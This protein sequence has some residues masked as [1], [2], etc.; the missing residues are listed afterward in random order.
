MRSA[1]PRVSR[2]TLPVSTLGGRALS[3]CSSLPANCAS[4]NG[5]VRVP[6]ADKVPCS[7][8]AGTSCAIVRSE[9]HTSELQSQSN[10]VCRLLL[11]KKKKPLARESQDHRLVRQPQTDLLC[12][13]LPHG[14]TS[15]LPQRRVPAKRPAN[16]PTTLAPTAFQRRR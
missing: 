8:T 2:R 5:P 6:A 7:R 9:E 11:E 13:T 16:L 14:A 12:R 4:R 3:R 10:L 15:V 1:S